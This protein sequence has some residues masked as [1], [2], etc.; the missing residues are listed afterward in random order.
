MPKKLDPERYWPQVSTIC[1]QDRVVSFEFW[2]SSFSDVNHPSHICTVEQSLMMLSTTDILW[3]LGAKEF[4]ALWPHIRNS[5]TSSRTS[6]V[7]GRRLLDGLWSNL[8][9]GNIFA[10]YRE[11]RK[12]LSKNVRTTY[13][14][15][16]QHTRITAYDIA[17][18][19]KRHYPSVHA[20]VQFL[21]SVG[22]V[23]SAY[24]E[25][26]GRRVKWLMAT[27]D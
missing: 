21:I 14:L 23:V 4:F 1:F 25:R 19:S 7:M 15:I 2:R 12:P 27:S 20:D 3:L 11:L 18:K 16:F 17:K 24:G 6:I 22:L 10:P 26:N 8:T 9:T 5:K 13:D